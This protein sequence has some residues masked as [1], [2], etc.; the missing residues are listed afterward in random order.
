[1]ILAICSEVSRSPTG[2]IANPFF[3]LETRW[4]RRLWP[5]CPGVI[6]APLVPPLRAVKRT[7]SGDRRPEGQNSEFRNRFGSQNPEF[8]SAEPEVD[9]FGGIVR[10]LTVAEL[11]REDESL[12]NIYLLKKAQRLT[13]QTLPKMR[14]RGL[15]S[16]N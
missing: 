16:N 9:A 5:L 8:R 3:E 14:S 2:G 4:M 10:D 11:S 13:L 1:M 6:T 15:Y 12:R 7:R